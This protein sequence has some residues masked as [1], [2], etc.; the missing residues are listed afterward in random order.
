MTETLRFALALEALWLAG[1]PLAGRALRRLPGQGLGFARVLALLLAGWLVWLLGSLGVPNGSWL[2]VGA[3]LVVALGSLVTWQRAAPLGADPFRRRAL[4]ASEAVFGIAFLA[5]AVLMAF[6]PDVLGTEKLMDVM[7][8]NATLTADAFPP[9]DPW[10]SGEELNYYYLGHLLMGLLVRVTDVEPT[11]GYNLAMATVFALTASAAFSLAATFAEGLRRQG[12]PVRAPLAAGGAAV[13]LLALMGNLR[14][15][16]EAMTH[17]APVERFPWFDGSRVVPD[18]INEFPYFTFLVGDLHAHF[19]AV[20]LTLLAVAFVVQAALDGPPRLTGGR[21]WWETA[22]AALAVGV[23]YAVNSWSW[24]VMAGLLLL[25][26]L[27]WTTGARSGRR[28][29]AV[30]AAIVLLLGTVLVLPFLVSFEANA[31]GLGLVDAR[32]RE[33]LGDFLGHNAVLY[34][35]LLWLLVAPFAARLDRVRHPVRLLVWGTAVVAVVLSA[36]ATARLAGAALVL[37][38]AGVALWAA[39]VPARPT[40][41]RLLWGFAA[42]G[43]VLIAGPEVA[44]VRDEFEGT[45]FVRMNTV[46]KMGY[47]AWLVLAVAGAVV[48]AASEAWLSR[49]PRLA[50]GAVALLL[51]G[52]GLAYAPVATV[53]RKAS[54]ADGPRLDGR[55]WLRDTAPGDVAAID[56]IRASV[57]RDAV[58]LEAVGDDYSAFGNARISSY[59]GRQTVLGWQGHELQWNHEV[60][61]RRPDVET[62]YTTRDR[63]EARRL[64]DRYGVGYAVLGPLERTFYGEPGVLPAL[65]RP[66]FRRA[67]TVVYR[68]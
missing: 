4:V 38:L 33:P 19:I 43:L 59:T 2:V 65:G 68:F 26:V 54:F 1:L 34:G 39:L 63:A 36:T 50:W 10:L 15:G 42:A 44:Y 20:P 66:V 48:L 64:L 61:T 9:A 62:L 28:H 14:A 11:A 37:L 17:A 24:P 18:T 7:L 40:G 25:G 16:W 12:A 55:A 47:Q 60:G 13:A 56:W 8:L 5:G 31:R 57:P 41:E 3:A 22:V 52:V 30:W 53:A 51:V 27:V 67:G 35:A 21:D 6:S 46:F 32:E 45:A 49:L 58:V 23:L 29:A